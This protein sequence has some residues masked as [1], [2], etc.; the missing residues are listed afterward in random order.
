M[1]EDFSKYEKIF[2]DSELALKHLIQNNLKKKT[3]ILTF[4][5]SIISNKYKY[6]DYIICDI[7]ENWQKNKLIKYQNTKKNF[8]IKVYK[9][10]IDNNYDKYSIL[11][12]NFIGVY[13][14]NIYK[15]GYLKNKDLYESA[16]VVNIDEKSRSILQYIN[17]P[18]AR[19]LKTNKKLDV[20]RYD[21]KINENS[22]LNNP[23]FFLRLR[24]AGIKSIFYRLFLNLYNSNLFSFHKTKYFVYK[25]NELIKETGYEII[26]NFNILKKIDIANIKLNQNP[27]KIQLNNNLIF[28]LENNL[29]KII[30]ER[31]IDYIDHE[32]LPNLLTMMLNDL[33]NSIILHDNYFLEW[34]KYF[35]LKGKSINVLTNFPGDI[36]DTALLNFLN[37]NNG[38][39]SSFQHG[40]W[41]EIS[42]ISD[43][44][45]ARHEVNNSHYFFGF[46]KNIKNK[47]DKSTFKKS[48]NFSVGM[49]DIILKK[50][51]NL[52]FRDVLYVAMNLY[53]GNCNLLTGVL[54][55]YQRYN[56]ELYIINK[57]LKN[58][59]KPVDYKPY[60]LVNLRYTEEDPIYDILNKINSINIISK[61]IDLRYIIKNYKLIISTG[62]SSTLSWILI[63][64]VP[65]V[66]IN[67]SEKAP[68]NN[69][70]KIELSKSI[71]YFD[72]DDVDFEDKL[73]FFLNKS[74]QEIY[75]LWNQKFIYRKNF[76]YNNICESNKDSGKKIFKIISNLID[77]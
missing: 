76:I 50:N 23:S 37:E 69:E 19:L 44:E 24:S 61:K 40:V 20:Y 32:I 27:N 57:F 18:W 74:Y 48:I 55:D 70:L 6:K 63:S 7:S 10:C 12:S 1:K 30:Y 17:P 56:Y 59:N 64:N 67:N 72:K 9:E 58:I 71:F 38:K 8:Y 51:T 45:Y 47:Y 66:Y 34:S 4:S 28:F 68:L 21:I 52:N 54:S 29:K 2:C 43:E 26:R 22:I 15:S 33:K 5:P 62:A 49:P 16:L 46:N 11:I 65:F 36:K 13:C 14:R 41:S 42:G 31:L 35:K 77:D 75:K 3:K 39:L 73:K 60:P 53:R 25:E